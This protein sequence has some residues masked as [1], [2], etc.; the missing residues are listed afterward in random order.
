MA[1][2]VPPWVPL[3]AGLPPPPVAGAA[4]LHR[5]PCL[6]PSEVPSLLSQQRIGC[7]SGYR[8]SSGGQA[9]NRRCSSSG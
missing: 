2:I 7:T 5:S 9:S 8:S 3:V 1:A 6:P 4:S